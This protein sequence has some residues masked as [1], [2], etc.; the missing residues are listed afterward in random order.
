MFKHVFAK[1]TLITVFGLTY[2]SGATIQ[3]TDTL[4]PQLTNWAGT[5]SVPK[6]NPALGSLTKVTLTLEGTVSGNIFLENLD[7]DPAILNASDSVTV[8]AGTPLGFLVTTATAPVV[9]SATPFDGIQDEAGTSGHTFLNMLATIASSE[10]STA[11]LDLAQFTGSGSILMNALFNGHSTVTGNGNLFAFFQTYGGGSMTVVY[12]FTGPETPVPETKS[13][14][15]IGFGLSLIG[16][17]KRFFS[18]N[19]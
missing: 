6:F 18:S 4:S 9:F 15:G 19:S 13:L 5:F 11:P 14:L 3:F 7:P 2:S 1:L 16:V 12:D 17:K 8:A 10:S